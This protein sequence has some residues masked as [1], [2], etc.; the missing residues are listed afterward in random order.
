MINAA[1]CTAKAREWAAK[2]ERALD[3]PFKAR[4]ERIARYWAML[5]VSVATDEG[6]EAQ[7]RGQVR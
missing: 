2:A 7:R 6:L 5:A 3:G 4:L 1:K